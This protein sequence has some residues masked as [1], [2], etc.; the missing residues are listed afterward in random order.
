[1]LRDFFHTFEIPDADLSIYRT[2]VQLLWGY[3][4]V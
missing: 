3:D 2:T 1:M 4:D